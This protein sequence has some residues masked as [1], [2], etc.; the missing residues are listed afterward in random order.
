M[1][2]LLN[3]DARFRTMADHA[4][5]L[6]WMTGPQGLC[7]FFN[8]G[9]LDFTGRTLEQELGNGW[10]EGVHPED[11]QACMHTFLDAFV[12]RKA[13]SMHYRLRRHDGEYRWIFDQGAPHFEAEGTFA[14]FIG[15]CV[16]VTDQRQAQHA[17][18]RLNDV[19]ENRV[20]ERTAIAH[21]RELL[22]KEVHHRVKNDLQLIASLLGMHAR[23][24]GDDDAIL[25]MEDC[26]S[27]VQTVALIH[28]YMYQSDD[29]ARLPFS[30]SI[31]S[32]AAGML[33]VAGMQSPAVTLEVEADNEVILRMDRAIPCCLILNEL[34]TNVLKHAFP[35]G[36][37]G[38]LRIT[39]AREADGRLSLTVA[40]DGVGLPDDLAGD[41]RTAFGWTLVTTFA[42]QLGADLAVAREGGSSVR[43]VFDAERR[44]GE[45][46]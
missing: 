16:D 23:R 27:R 17:L 35:G 33:R 1:T 29:L 12:A 41:A 5:V 11:F 10:A 42:R 40:D 19:L 4:P 7:E 45:A 6:L 8:Q 21:E 9:W 46:A 3:R 26:R 34:V 31:R 32:L 38:T 20:R 14:G 30:Q 22:I 24:L 28:E 18:R 15:S 43:L 25:A 39:L 13:F 44:K 36:R 2:E 37:R